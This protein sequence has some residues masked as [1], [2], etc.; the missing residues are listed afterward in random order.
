MRLFSL[1]E[2]GRLRGLLYKSFQV[3]GYNSH[4]VACADLKSHYYK[5]S[6]LL[7]YT[8]VPKSIKKRK[9]KKKKSNNLAGEG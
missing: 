9:R 4:L 1:F 8:I 5:V 6:F 3:I 2:F 7:G